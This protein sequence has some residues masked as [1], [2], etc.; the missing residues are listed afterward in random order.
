MGLHS[1]EFYLPNLCFFMSIK[2]D[3]RSIIFNQRPILINK[4]NNDSSKN[5]KNYYYQYII[6][7]T[8][9]I[10]IFI[11]IFKNSYFS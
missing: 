1:M 6:Y 4:I 3:V 10:F 5:C 11:F 8:G 9:A 7:F 2:F